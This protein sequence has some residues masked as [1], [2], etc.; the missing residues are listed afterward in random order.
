MENHVNEEHDKT[1]SQA[2]LGVDLSAWEPTAPRAGFA[3]RVLAETKEEGPP[4]MQRANRSWNARRVLVASSLVASVVLAIGFGRA[5]LGRSSHGDAIAKER[6][7]V[8]FGRGVAVLEPGAH[9]TW[10]DDEIVQPAGDIFYRVERGET[11]RVKTP[12]G[13]VEVRG[14]CFRVHVEP[15][16]PTNGEKDHDM[17]TRDLKSAAIGAA[18]TSIAFVTV[19]EGKVAVSHAAESVTL[20]AGESARADGAGVSKIGGT[21]SS[22]D[23]EHALSADEALAAAN[24]NLVGDVSDYR[25]KL[26]ALDA[27]KHEVETRLGAAEKKLAATDAQALGTNPFDLAKEDWSELAKTGTVKYKLPCLK[28]DGWKPG[29]DDLNKLGL[30]PT[31]A[32]TIQDAYK[33]STARVW[34]VLKP[35]CAQAVGSAE[36]AERIGPDSCVHIILDLEREQN[37]AAANQAMYDIGAIRSGKKP[38]PA[39]GE[40]VDPVL[41][42]FLTLTDGTPAFERDLAQS[43]GPD[44]AHRLAYADGMCSGSSIFGGPGMKR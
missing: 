2:D 32:P 36:V 8:P 15:A 30:A 12:A 41:Q 22:A 6:T 5:R 27:E 38:V 35:L 4:R 9:M 19:Y 20:T 21:L 18:L 40:Q 28:F 42:M 25:R 33:R 43:F 1:E 7:E 10:N 11:F 31:D 13:D 17:N 23:S 3:E 16:V 29:A 14:T 37:S 34:A 24:E 44:E 26:E 39:A